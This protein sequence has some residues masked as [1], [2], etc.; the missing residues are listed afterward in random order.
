MSL[1]TAVNY[2][3]NN[4]IEAFGVFFSICYLFNSVRGKMWLWIFGIIS[5]VCYLIVFYQ[6]RF[7]ALGLLQIYYITMSVYGLYFWIR[8]KGE[9]TDNFVKISRITPRQ[10][11]IGIATALVC[12]SILFFVIRNYTDSPVPLGDSFTTSL[13]IV[14]TWL[15][16]RKV[17]E[18]WLMFIVADIICIGL[19]V[20]QEMYLTALLFVIYST[21]GVIGYCRWYREFRQQL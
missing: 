4:Y 1:E 10:T 13:C 15:L 7:Y 5:A 6:S 14:G 9:D 11:V 18:N 3:A 21:M 8:H 20:Y 2:L 16:A 17:L 12:F 19:F